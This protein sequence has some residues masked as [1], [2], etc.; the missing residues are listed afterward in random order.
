MQVRYKVNPTRGH[1]NTDALE[2]P[3]S[4]GT[5]ATFGIFIMYYIIYYNGWLAPTTLEFMST[6]LYAVITTILIT[7]V[8]GGVG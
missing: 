1:F 3:I 2:P 6:P 7:T 5:L 8:L 4:P